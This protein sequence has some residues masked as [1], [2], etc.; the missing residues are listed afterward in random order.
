MLEQT[1]AIKNEVRKPIKLF[2][3]YLTVNR[4]V[5]NTMVSR[6]FKENLVQNAG[7]EKFLV[8]KLGHIFFVDLWLGTHYE[9][10]VLIASTTITKSLLSYILCQLS[11]TPA[12][13]K[14]VRSVSDVNYHSLTHIGIISPVLRNQNFIVT[15]IDR[16]EDI[17]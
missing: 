8:F 7:L 13:Q 2:L 1:D 12:E 5:C 16:I 17:K 4:K 6:Y 10:S 15:S 3:A 14:H 11:S 9:S